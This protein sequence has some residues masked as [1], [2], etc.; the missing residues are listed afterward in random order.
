MKNLI[1]IGKKGNKV[2]PILVEGQDNMAI[3]SNISEIPP[4]I[5]DMSDEIFVIDVDSHE[6]EIL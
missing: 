4:E 6:L 5:D 1:V 3:F 2:F